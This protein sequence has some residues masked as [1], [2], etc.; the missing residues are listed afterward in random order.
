M[1]D[2][3]KRANY[4]MLLSSAKHLVQTIVTDV[5]HSVKAFEH[6]FSFL[7]EKLINMGYEFIQTNSIESIREIIIQSASN[8][9]STLI[10]NEIS[11][12]LNFSWSR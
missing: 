9:S 11:Q 7:N 1:I 8:I 10:K 2:I 3:D 4:N 5:H 6:I 12:F